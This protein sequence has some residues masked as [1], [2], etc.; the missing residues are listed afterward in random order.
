MVITQDGRERPVQELGHGD[1]VCLAFADDAEQRRVL[2]AYLH[3]GLARGERVLYFAEQQDPA[4]VLE[5][6][7]PA[8]AE[9]DTA[10]A[11]GQLRVTTADDSYLAAGRFD[12]ETMVATLR[13]EVTDSLK[14]GYTGLRVS[15][16]MSWG[17]RDVPGVDQL[18]EYEAKVNAVFAGQRASAVCQYDARLFA[19]NQ[20]DAFDRCHPGTV[21]A[22]PLHSDGVLH[23][24]PAFEE[25]ERVL[26]MAGTVDY[27]TT[28]ALATALETVLGWSG[29]VRVDLGAL[30][31]ID[32][33]GLR[34][35]AHTAG[36]LTRGRRLRVTGLAPMLCHV[37]SVAGFDQ[38]DALV[39]IPSEVRA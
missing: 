27:R 12:A 32:L 2:T 18:A 37:I 15:G 19:P 36:Q 23:I 13:Q 3:E 39:V 16:E 22:E 30:E 4:V 1:H 34:A 21:E 38:Q 7:R 24:L 6:L 31:F 11:R 14:A 5:W 25:G 9:V 33:A 28:G 20:L 8:G 17:L 26:R 29:D 35:L 10:V